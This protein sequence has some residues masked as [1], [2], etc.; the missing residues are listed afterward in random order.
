MSSQCLPPCQ[1]PHAYVYVGMVTLLHF[2]CNA[3]LY[4]IL[5]H[6]CPGKETSVHL[7]HSRAS[8]P[9]MALQLSP[10]SFMVAVQQVLACTLIELVS[11]Y[12]LS[13]VGVTLH[14][15]MQPLPLPFSTATYYCI[16]WEKSGCGWKYLLARS[17]HLS[18]LVWS[19]CILI[20]HMHAVTFM[21]MHELVCNV[22]LIF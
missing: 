12:I 17:Y 21:S 22:C 9:S 18:T 4:Y 20:K 1:C 16:D 15:P 7:D 8:L 5:S 13:S 11:S 3:W 2:L 6:A 14:I 19:N 10:W